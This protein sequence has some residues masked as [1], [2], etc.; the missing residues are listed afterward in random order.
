MVWAYGLASRVAEWVL[1]CFPIEL[2]LSL[3]GVVGEE[4]EAPECGGKNQ[5]LQ[6]HTNGFES[7]FSFAFCV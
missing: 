6:S 4:N 5:G 2:K 3:E 1:K 7:T